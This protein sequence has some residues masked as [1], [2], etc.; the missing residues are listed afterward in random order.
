[1]LYFKNLSCTEI[2]SF[3]NYVNRSIYQY[4]ASMQENS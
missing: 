3:D 1:M 2:V 4:N